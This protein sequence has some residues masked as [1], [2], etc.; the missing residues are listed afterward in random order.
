MRLEIPKEELILF[1]QR[2]WNR[3]LNMEYVGSESEITAFEQDCKR[4]GIKDPMDIMKSSFYP[5]L[6]QK[7]KKSWMHLFTDPL[8]EETYWQGAAWCLKKE[9]IAGEE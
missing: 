8:P 4:Q 1:D 2:T 9:W 5:L 3:I 6:S 7:V